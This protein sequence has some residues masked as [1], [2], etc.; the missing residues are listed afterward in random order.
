MAVSGAGADDIRAAAR[1]PAVLP[2]T[3]SRQPLGA[4]E[5]ALE[6]GL[7]GAWQERNRERTIPHAIASM[8]AAGNLDDLRAAVDGPGERPVPRYPFLDT[9]VYKTLEGVAYEVGRGVATPGMRAFL[10]EATDV[11]E[12]VQADDGYIGSYV[13]RPGSDREP[14]SD[15]A[16]GHEL[17]NLGHLIQAAVA[18]SRQGGE[19][20]LLAVARRFADAAVR[21]FGPDGRAEVC[22]HPEVEMALVELHRETG[23]RAY[24]DLASAFVDRRGHGTVATRIFPAEYFQDAHPFREMPAVTGH[25]VRMAYLAAGATDVATETGDA[26]LLAASIRLFDDAVRTR[27]YVTGGLGSR[28][29][30]EAIGDAYELP[31]E[32]SYSETCAAIAVMQWAWRL[33]LATGEPRFLDAHE[34]VLLNAYA[35][36]LSADGT[37]FFYDNPLQRRPDHHAQSGAEVEGEL[38][39]RPW[40][41][42]PCCPPNIVRWMSELQDHVAVRDGDDLVIAHPAACVI[43]TAALDVRVTTAYPWDGSIRVEVLRASGAEAG[44]VLRRPGWCRSATAV[45]QGA[46]GSAEVDAAAADRWIRATRAWAPGDALVVELDMPVR[47]L[48]SHPHLDAT[49]GSLA[50]ARGPVVYAVE[51][52]DAGA[53]VDDLLLDPRDLAAARTVPLPVDAPWGP[54]SAATDPAS[55]VALSLRLRRAVPAPDELYPEVVPGTAAPAPSADPVDAVLVP[56][57]L[58]GNRDAGAMRVWIRA[59]DTG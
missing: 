30:D 2:T 57:A 6:G 16:W 44:I 1:R 47:A 23:E 9:D 19:G 55:G 18:D 27:L 28:H 56:Y 58:W 51:Q 17:Y 20:R 39:R 11:L 7:L 25:A 40:F 33:F 41:T 35:V 42:C 29:S 31:S 50:V 13:Q 3:G 22:G 37:G 59:A 5:V 10:A 24:L 8:A 32:R 45:V 4:G 54:A 21:E 36:G 52:E 43:R 49:R 15:L 48:G 12:R 34:T 46:D 38:L 53:P 14:W 26:E